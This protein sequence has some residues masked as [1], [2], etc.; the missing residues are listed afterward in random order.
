MLWG[1][2]LYCK[3]FH[4]KKILIVFGVCVFSF[5]AL[6]GRL[7]Y[8]MIF[9]SAYYQQLA[10]DLHERERSIKAARGRI[11]D[12][13]GTILADNR[14]VCTISVIHSQVKNRNRSFRC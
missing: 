3:T 1:A 4:R 6:A 11:I 8:L 2:F 5:F 10:K 9:E 7:G 12:R 13:N 14:T